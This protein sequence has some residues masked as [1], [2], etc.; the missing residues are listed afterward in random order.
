V[1]YNWIENETLEASVQGLTDLHG[2]PWKK[3]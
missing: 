2:N 3:K 1:A